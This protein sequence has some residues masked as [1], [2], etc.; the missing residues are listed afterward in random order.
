MGPLRSYLDG[1]ITETKNGTTSVIFTQESLEKSGI[2]PRITGAANGKTWTL[3]DCIQIHRSEVW[4]GSADTGSET[5]LANKAFCGI[6]FE[7]DEASQFRKIGCWIDG[8]A[9]WV[10]KSGMTEQVH[11]KEVEGGNLTHVKQALSVAPLPKDEV[12]LD[13]GRMLSVDHHY[14]IAG[15]SVTE[16][17]FT[18]DFSFAVAHEDLVDLPQLL[19]TT[20]DLQNLVSIGT[21]RSSG[22]AKLK[23]YHPDASID[24]Q[25]K[26][27]ELPIDFYARWSVSTPVGKKFN[28]NNMLF[29][30][31]DLG[32]LA[33]VKKWLQVSEEYRSELN[34]VMSI[35]YSLGMPA[36]D[37]LFNCAAAL[38]AYDRKKHKDSRTFAERLQRSIDHAGEAITNI[39]DDV[40]TW[41]KLLKDARND[42][43]HHNPGVDT[44][45]ASHHIMAE[46]AYWLF[47]LCLLKDASAPSQV[48]VSIAEQ[49][50]QGSLPRRV[51]Q[52]LAAQNCLRRTEP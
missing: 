25:G 46:S 36:S 48:F 26:V 32:G 50:F 40:P 18:Q 11:Y 10:M 33:G 21:G 12:P 3:E 30:L 35:K 31:K 14:G 39:V 28:S 45:Y 2:Y 27:V 37:M 34:R 16:R 13:G 5:I 9:Y 47:V 22:Y 7:A 20:S 6:G 19:K 4:G 24:V 1:G 49:H 8:L 44:A 17:K 51:S 52:I 29:T 41:E 15:D 43:A 23:L 38:E 42:V